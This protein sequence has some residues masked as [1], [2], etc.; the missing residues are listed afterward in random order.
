MFQQHPSRILNQAFS[1]RPYQGVEPDRAEFLFVGLDANYSVDLERLEVFRDVLDYHEDGA[2]FWRTHGVHHPFLLPNYRGDGQRY[3]RNFARIGF[4][5]AHADRVSFVELL[6]VPT[7][8]RSQLTPQD[9]DHS[10]LQK[11]D[12]AIRSGMTR[13][14]FLSAGVAKLMQLSGAFPW[15]DTKN[16][17]EGIL[18][19]LYASHGRSVHLHLHFSN[20]GKFRAQMEAEAKAIS[21]MLGR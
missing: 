4:T 8:G 15:L 13:Y 11:L 6:H 20:Y 1:D 18:P 10:H 19:V 14:T 9:L 5:P 2:T 16:R 21:L 12:E 17:S 3:H 7:V